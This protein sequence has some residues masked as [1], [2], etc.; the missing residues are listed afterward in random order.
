MPVQRAAVGV[1]LAQAGGG[2][3]VDLAEGGRR[4]LAAA[5]LAQIQVER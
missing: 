2:R 3:V 5:P 1:Q 4:A